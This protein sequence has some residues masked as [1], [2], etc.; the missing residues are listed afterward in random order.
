MFFTVVILIV[1]VLEELQFI[2]NNHPGLWLTFKYLISQVPELIQLIIPLAV[3][4]GVLMALSTLAK[5]SELMAMRAGGANIYQ[6]VIPLF[7]AGLVIC[8]LSLVFS[9]IVVPKANQIRRH[10]QEVEIEHKPESSLETYRQNLSLRG[11]NNTLYH[12]G[13]FDGT[14]NTMTDILV[15][16]FDN[17]SHL[18][19]RVDAKAA[20]YQDGRWIF[21]NG[22]IRTFNG[23]DNEV[24]TLPFDQTVVDLTEKPSD[25]IKEQKELAELSI[26]ELTLYIQQLKRN[27]L[28]CHKE[29]VELNNKLAF[30][31]GCVILALWGVPWGWSMGKYSGVVASFGICLLVGLAYIGGMQIGHTLGDGGAIPPFFAIWSIN[32]I[33]ALMG[34]LLILRKN[35]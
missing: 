4:F 13:T 25:F 9:E 27:G 29:L 30:P 32:L 1:K 14:K 8:I 18:K 35:N 5:N 33:F 22:Y 11:D 3:L 20:H 7:F 10:T 23:D 24:Q 26:A 19:S 15:L 28:D 12:I 31:F 6:A 21:E 2:L 17:A 34:P 16:Q